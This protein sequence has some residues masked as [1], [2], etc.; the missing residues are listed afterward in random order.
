M[1]RDRSRPRRPLTPVASELLWRRNQSGPS[2]PGVHH[3]LPRP[4]PALP[5]S[6][7]WVRQDRPY[8]LG[9]LHSGRSSAPSPRPFPAMSD[10]SFLASRWTST[11]TTPTRLTMVR[12]R[13]P[14][15]IS[16]SRRRRTGAPIGPV[17]ARASP[18][19]SG[20]SAGSFRCASDR[21]TEGLAP[22]SRAP[23]P[24]SRRALAEGEAPGVDHIERVPVGVLEGRKVASFLERLQ[25]PGPEP[26]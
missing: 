25:H 8:V 16:R 5:V 14:G 3:A 23:K 13:T 15:G 1:A 2:P 7:W 17:A 4:C 10:P 22:R 18:S 26:H 11:S 20:T 9:N 24:G 21:R 6:E 19:S 12:P